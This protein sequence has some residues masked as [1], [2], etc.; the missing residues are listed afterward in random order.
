MELEASRGIGHQAAEPS[1]CVVEKK[2]GIHPFR[3]IYFL[4]SHEQ[5]QGCLHNMELLN[6]WKRYFLFFVFEKNVNLWETLK[7]KLFHPLLRPEKF[8]IKFNRERSLRYDQA[9]YMMPDERYHTVYPLRGF[10][11]KTLLQLTP[12]HKEYGYEILNQ[13]GVPKDAFFV[14][15]HARDPVFYTSFASE[16][17]QDYERSNQRV[18]DINVDSY[19][20]ALKRIVEKGGYCI[21]IGSPKIDPLPQRIL[22]LGHVIDYPKSQFVSPK[23]DV[24]L[25]AETKFLLG[26]ASGP[27]DVPAVFGKPMVMANTVQF[28]GFSPYPDDLMTFKKYYSKK[29]NRYLSIDE[30]T[31]PPYRLLRRDPEFAELGVMTIDNTEEEILKVVEEMFAK[32]DGSLTYSNQDEN[33]QKQFKEKLKTLPCYP[34]AGRIGKDFLAENQGIFFP[35][36]LET[37]SE[38]SSNLL[39]IV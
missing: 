30:I 19:Y 24:F 1:C 38:K 29:L 37:H 7:F 27:A 35:E 18:R 16:C 6:Y 34:L 2:L 15:F 22:D 28:W 5:V 26:C 21:R 20:L 17:M 10:Y 33:L 31:K 39:H 36:N 12:S 9:P 4:S 11:K 25:L 32:L 3:I 23:M 13:L 14:A 8:S